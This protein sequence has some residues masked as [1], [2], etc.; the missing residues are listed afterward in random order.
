MVFCFRS[1]SQVSS[2]C[3]CASMYKCKACLW[4]QKEIKTGLK[5]DTF[6]IQQFASVFMHADF[7]QI[8]C[9]IFNFPVVS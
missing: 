3:V 8:F 9:T 5:Y 6:Q 4:K 1:L 2:V 7:I